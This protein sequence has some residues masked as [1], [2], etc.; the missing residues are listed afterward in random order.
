MQ[1]DDSLFD[2]TADAYRGH[3]HWKISEEDDQCR[4]LKITPKASVAAE[5]R[6]IRKTPA[7]AAYERLLTT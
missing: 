6:I 7:E 2:Q 5:W 4:R 1:A 3:S